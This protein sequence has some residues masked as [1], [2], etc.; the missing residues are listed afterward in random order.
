MCYVGPL[1]GAIVASFLWKKTKSIKV[2]WLTLLFWGGALFGV[3]DHLLNGEL[4]LI[5]ENIAWDLLLGAIITV[6]TLLAWR[7]VLFL[8][9]KNPVLRRAFEK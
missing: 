3:I 1:S 7:A 6:S 4:F 8:A 2:F 5:S 9:Q